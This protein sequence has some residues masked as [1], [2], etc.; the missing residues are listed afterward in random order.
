MNYEEMLRTQEMGHSHREELS[1][2]VFCKKLLDKKYRNVVLL[3]TELTENLAFCEGLKND[4]QAGSAI[5]HVGQMHYELHADSGGYYELELESGNILTLAQLIDTSP[6]VVTKPGFIDDVIRTLLDFTCLLHDRSIY[7]LC[8]SPQEIFLR[9]GEQTPM[10]LCHGSS[11][12]S[13]TNFAELYKGYEQFVAPEVLTDHKVGE[14]QDVY[15][16]GR[17]IEWLFQNGDLPYEYKA[18]VKKATQDVPENRYASVADM[19][20]DLEKKRNLK[21]S[22][23]TFVAA[24]AAVLLCIFLYFELVPQSANIEFVEGAQKQQEAAADLSE[25]GFNPETELGLWDEVDSTLADDTLSVS[26]RAQMDA[27]MRKAEDIFRKQYQREADRIISKVYSKEGM[28][29][30][31]NVF[32]AATNT[33]TDELKEAEQRLAGDAGISDEKAVR[34]AAEINEQLARDKQRN[35]NTKSGT[36][37]VLHP[38]NITTE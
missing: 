20:H 37:G 30:S 25:E 16:L 6:A 28:S 15:A 21:R 11:F 1:L 7:Q 4:Q 33:M 36:H 38:K 13:R 27:Y 23:F 19:K 8:Y 3:K 10:L 12:G 34:I 35:L 5:N 17:F 18:V 32:V 2:G 29:L 24:V 22:L 31:E 9:K 26:E 14:A